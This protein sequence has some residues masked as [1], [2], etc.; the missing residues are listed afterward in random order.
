[1]VEEPSDDEKGKDADDITKDKLIQAPKKK[2]AATT[3]SKAKS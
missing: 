3:K 2:K 1:M